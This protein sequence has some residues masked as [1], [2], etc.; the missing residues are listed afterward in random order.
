MGLRLTKIHLADFLKT[1]QKVR[2]WPNLRFKI[3]FVH[4]GKQTRLINRD[5]CV[6]P[7]NLGLRKNHLGQFLETAQI[8]RDWPNLRF[9]I[10]FVHCGKQTRLINRDVCVL[11]QYGVAENP[12]GQFSRNGPKSTG[13]TQFTF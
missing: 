8:V 5:V 13:L 10:A 3:A 9:K 6:L 4:C 7:D 1:A 2:A 12:V 11:G